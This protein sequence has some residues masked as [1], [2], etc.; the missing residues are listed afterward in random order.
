[1][2]AKTGRPSNVPADVLRAILTAR[3]D[4]FSYNANCAAL[5]ADGVP[6]SQGGT[7]WPATVRAVVLA[8]RRRVGL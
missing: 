2:T 1:M 4:G 3:A 5:I 8:H 6:T 7:W